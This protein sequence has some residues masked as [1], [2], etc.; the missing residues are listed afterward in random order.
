MTVEDIEHR[1]CDSWRRGR[2]RAP[3]RLHLRV[4]ISHAFGENVYYFAWRLIVMVQILTFRIP[5]V[6]VRR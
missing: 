5:T 1:P 3:E 4:N 6:N 2:H